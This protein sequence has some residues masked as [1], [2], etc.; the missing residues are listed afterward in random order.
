MLRSQY[1]SGLWGGLSSRVASHHTPP[2]RPDEFISWDSRCWTDCF[3]TFG[4]IEV[5][6]GHRMRS[7]SQDFD[8]RAKHYNFKITS[9]WAMSITKRTYDNTDIKTKISYVKSKHKG[10]PVN[11][12]VSSASFGNTH[13]CAYT[14]NTVQNP[15][16]WDNDR[17]K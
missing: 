9:F 14:Y 2:I 5:H 10:Y 15:K 6:R 11:G 3:S 8:C 12:N 16:C 13:R 7:A 1:L 4:V 17:A